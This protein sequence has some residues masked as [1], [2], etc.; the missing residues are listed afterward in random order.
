MNILFFG[1]PPFAAHIL[2]YLIKQGHAPKAIITRTDKPKG[3][4]GK[5]QP[6]A[7]TQLALEKVPE[8]PLLQPE[9]ASTPEFIT[10]LKK[11]KPDLLV[12]VAYGEI[13][14]QE[15]LDLPKHDAINIHASILPKYRGAAPIQHAIINGDNETGVTI[16]EMVKEL[17]AGPIIDVAHTPIYDNTTSGDLF[18]KL[19]DLSGPLLLRVIDNYAND[20]IKKQDQDQKQ[21]TFAPKITPDFCR[22]NWSL[23]SNAVHNHIRALSPRPGAWTKYGTRRIKIYKSKQAPNLSGK[24]GQIL[25]AVPGQ[26][27]IGCGEGAVQILEL[28]PEGKKIMQAEEFLCRNLKNSCFE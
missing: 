15:L 1:T 2:S 24:P 7:V 27:H 6:T 22:I 18:A 23:P 26:L 25:N 5:P 10:K 14:K 11:Y 9:K 12:V 21:V 13:I 19:A 20:K 16:M 28:Q 4:S 17:D 3:R 8:I